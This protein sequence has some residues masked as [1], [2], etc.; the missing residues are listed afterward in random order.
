M[1]LELSHLYKSFN[2]QPVLR[3]IHLA[4]AE[5]EL[6]CLL[7]PS[8]SGKTTLLRL[9]AGL[10]QADAG[11]IHFEGRDLTPTPIH[12][13]G[14]GLMF[15]DLALFPHR[16]VYDNVAFGLRMA[17]QSH[18][19]IE[20]RVTE[21]LTLV[22][23]SG[24]AR[25]DVNLLSGGEQQRVALARALAPHPRLLMFDEP[26]GALDR[27]LREQLI[28]EIREILKRLQ[29]TAL[30]VTHDQA[31]AFAIAD[32][33]AILQ[34]GQIAQVGTPEELYRQ[35]ASEFVARFLDLGCVVRGR[36][37]EDEWVETP[38]GRLL[39]REQ[40]RT[41]VIASETKQSPSLTLLLRPEG[42]QL[43]SEL[44][45]NVLE[46]IVTEC[47]FQR[48]VYRVTV[49]AHGFSLR[50]D[51]VKHVPEQTQLRFKVEG[52]VIHNRI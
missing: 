3:D 17:H 11:T 2:G 16:N 7:G 34:G 31:E 48:G 8:G 49:E 15:Q 24:F 46:G 22:G 39:M 52:E 5:G 18:A 35:P 28:G 32:R 37:I 6:V 29:L 47:R 51:C 44:G 12:A 50:F 1:L 19:A 20:A 33:I 41:K 40:S 45:E 36:W 43:V 9:I 13:R 10:E 30:Y 21:V 38:L 27:L 25:R 14:F 26:L 4:V 42:I 23:L